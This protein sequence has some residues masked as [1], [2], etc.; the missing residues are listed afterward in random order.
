MY[1]HNTCIN[2]APQFHHLIGPGFMLSVTNDVHLKILDLCAIN[3][4]LYV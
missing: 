2:M 1:I 4:L 3:I